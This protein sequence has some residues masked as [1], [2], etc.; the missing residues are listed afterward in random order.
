MKSW[1]GGETRSEIREGWRKLMGG[2]RWKKIDE[3]KKV[4]EIVRESVSNS[5]YHSPSPEKLGSGLIWPY[6][7]SR[8]TRSPSVTS[9]SRH[10]PVSRLFHNATWIPSVVSPD[11]SKFHLIPHRFSVSP[12]FTWC[13]PLSFYVL[14]S[15]QNIPD[16]TVTH[17]NSTDVSSLLIHPR[18]TFK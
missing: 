8:L 1:G 6:V 4:K 17:L 13:L 3:R 10:F 15:Q 2:R 12:N 7:S 18:L 11:V 5:R 14:R 16:R 9:F